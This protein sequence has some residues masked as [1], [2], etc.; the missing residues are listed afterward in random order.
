MF[1]SEAAGVVK[2]IASHAHLL[3]DPGH[4]SPEVASDDFHNFMTL[5]CHPNNK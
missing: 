5:G 3:S 1:E 2:G 4:P